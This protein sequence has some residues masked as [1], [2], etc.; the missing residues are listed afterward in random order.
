MTKN[1]ESADETTSQTAVGD[2]RFDHV[3]IA[4]HW[5]T[6]LLVIIQFASVWAIE[7]AGDRSSLGAALLSLHMTTG[8][9]TWFV[10]VVRL[11]W[12]HYFAY[13]PPFPPRMPKVQ[14][15]I[16]KANEYGL[17]FCC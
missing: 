10:V 4:L 2:G 16:A 15:A 14:Q 8:V 6:V 9:L 17:T 11:V 13:L 5:L 7:A 12:R 3:S 1:L